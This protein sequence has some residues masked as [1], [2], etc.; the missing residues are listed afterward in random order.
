MLQPLQQYELDIL[1]NLT[2]KAQLGQADQNELAIMKSYTDRYMAFN[3]QLQQNM[4]PQYNQPNMYGNPQPTYNQQMLPPQYNQPS[5][6]G[7]P[8]GQPTMMQPQYNQASRYQQ[9]FTSFGGNANAP[10]ANITFNNGTF[11]YA[12]DDHATPDIY[13]QKQREEEEKERIRLYNEYNKAQQQAKEAPVVVEK[14]KPLVAYPGSELPWLVPPHF[15]LSKKEDDFAYEY[16]VKENNGVVNM[17]FRD[18]ESIYHDR[19]ESEE[20]VIKLVDENNINFAKEEV[21][22]TLDLA[23]DHVMLNVDFIEEEVKHIVA[24]YIIATTFV[25]KKITNDETPYLFADIITRSDSLIALSF[26]IKRFLDGKDEIN[27]KA[28][29]KLD[30]ILTENVMLILEN[31]LNTDMYIESFTNDITELYD[32]INTNVTDGSKKNRITNALLNML[33]MI[34]TDNKLVYDLIKDE[35]TETNIGSTYFLEKT[36]FVVTNSDEI[37]YEINNLEKKSLVAVK[38]D[39]TPVLNDLIDKVKSKNN[40]FKTYIVDYKT[41]NVYLTMKN[42]NNKMNTILRVK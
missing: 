12:S 42:V 36:T 26:G 15:Y 13:N 24:P 17:N 40:T 21:I 5:Y 4:P 28:A 37:H 6:V 20:Y 10:T 25:A 18:H 29:M 27:K 14:K 11:K 9:P 38:S 35:P 8:T 16:E 41:G 34:K 22:E 32:Y 19:V 2:Q 31:I 1:R 3:P 30:T 7:Q 39:I 23:I 33:N